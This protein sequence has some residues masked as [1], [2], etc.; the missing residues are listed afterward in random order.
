MFNCFKIISYKVSDPNR[1]DRQDTNILADLKDVGLGAHGENTY[2]FKVSLPPNVV[3]PNFAQCGLFSVE[4][5]YKV[6]IHKIICLDKVCHIFLMVIAHNI[7]S[8][9]M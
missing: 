6:S 4:Y 7:S 8:N 5:V 2:I 9:I 1:D 3:I